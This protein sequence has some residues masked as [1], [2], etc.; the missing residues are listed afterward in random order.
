MLVSQSGVA[1]ALMP[2][3]VVLARAIAASTSSSGAR[4]AWQRPMPK[5]AGP[6]CGRW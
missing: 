2:G 1:M 3:R 6:A 4:F 5:P